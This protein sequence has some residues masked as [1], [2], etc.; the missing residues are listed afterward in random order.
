MKKKVFSVV[1]L[2]GFLSVLAAQNDLQ[3]IAQIN[4]SKKEPITLGQLKK[5]VK[6]AESQGG[7][8]KTS[9]DKKQILE[10]LMRTKLLVQVAEKENIKIANSQ[11][12]AAFNEAVST[13]V[14]YP[15]TESEFAKL[16]KREQNVSLD[17]FMKNLTGNN[18]EELKKIIKDN[19]TIQTYISSK[20]QAEIIKMATP[21]DA[22]I[23]SFYEMK[24]GELVRP[25]MVKMLL[26]AVK[27][28]GKDKE[29]IEKINNLYNRVKKNLKEIANIK[30]EAEK[31]NYIAQE[32]YIP[33]NAI[34]AQILNATPEALMDIFSKNVNHIFDIQDRADSRQ[35]FIIIEKLDAKILTLSDLPDPAS[36]VTL[37]DQIKGMLSQQM[38]LNAVE[39]IIQ[40]T[41]TSLKTDANCKI[42]KTNAELDKL[43]AW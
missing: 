37:Y 22:Q 42:L 8:I 25:D 31:N 18:V 2:I 10:R 26:V 32:G 5:L 20:N 14:N 16:I 41:Y 15:I 27:K 9:D 11:V 19:L 7:N 30:K 1:M 43:F 34:G 35:F 21:T 40:S 29:E 13:I 24:K 23:R 6:F 39:T 17:E 28:E 38:A 36:T 33:K 4:L 3:V 12:D